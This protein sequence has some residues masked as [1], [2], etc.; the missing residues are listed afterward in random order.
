MIF[1]HCGLRDFLKRKYANK[2]LNKKIKMMT[3]THTLSSDSG[4]C[5][6]L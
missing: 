2:T 1:Q 3:L 4:M 5:D 6:H